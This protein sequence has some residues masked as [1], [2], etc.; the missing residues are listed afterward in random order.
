LADQGVGGI[1]GNAYC[2]ARAGIVDWR[3]LVMAFDHEGPLPHPAG[4][5]GQ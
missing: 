2:R 1:V 3:N 4:D 5:R